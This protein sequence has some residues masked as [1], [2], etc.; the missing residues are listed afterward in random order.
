VDKEVPRD[1]ARSKG[2]AVTR[3]V[4]EV[5]NQAPDQEARRVAR[6]REVPDPEARVRRVVMN[7]KT[8]ATGP[9]LTSR[10]RIR[11]IAVARATGRKGR[12]QAEGP[13]DKG[14]AGMTGRVHRAVKEM[15]QEEQIGEPTGQGR[16]V[17]LMNAYQAEGP[18]HVKA[19][20]MIASRARVTIAATGRGTVDQTTGRATRPM[21]QASPDPGQTRK[22]RRSRDLE[23]NLNKMETAGEKVS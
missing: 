17:D 20:Q 19:V 16:K 9:L 15:N 5:R 3:I 23:Q 18:N 6:S 2:R 4:R 21:P 13:K 8:G 14:P 1:S 11:R 10:V 22:F 12:D 7:A